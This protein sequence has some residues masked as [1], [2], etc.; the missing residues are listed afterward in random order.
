MQCHLLNLACG[1]PLDSRMETRPPL[2]PVIRSFIL[3]RGTVDIMEK[4]KKT[5]VHRQILGFCRPRVLC[6]LRHWA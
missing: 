4:K 5:E 3:S 2:A 1:I 6:S